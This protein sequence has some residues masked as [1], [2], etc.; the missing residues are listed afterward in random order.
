[1]ARN[2]NFVN[3]QRVV[4]YNI[5][6]YYLAPKKE[7]DIISDAPNFDKMTTKELEDYVEELKLFTDNEVKEFQDSKKN[8]FYCG[9]GTTDVY[10]KRGLDFEI[11]EVLDR[12]LIEKQT[13]RIATKE[14]YFE[15]KSGGL[16]FIGDRKFTI[17]KVINQLIS[18]TTH[19]KI[20]AIPNMNHLHRFGEKIIVLL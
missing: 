12:Q 15:F 10:T 5:K 2:R 17:I 11:D 9:D 4:N 18:E 14:S 7:I 8:Y 3:A 6:G 20:K 19:Q 1:M 16:I 13:W